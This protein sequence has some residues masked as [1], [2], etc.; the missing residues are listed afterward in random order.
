V[1][2]VRL[3]YANEKQMAYKNSM[4]A[5]SQLPRLDDVAS[6]L[7]KPNMADRTKAPDSN[8]T[9]VNVVGSILSCPNAK[10]HS[11]E[12]A[13]KAIMARQVAKCIFMLLLTPD[14]SITADHVISRAMMDSK[15]SRFRSESI[16]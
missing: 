10:L 5:A 16:P 12:L 14:L 9:V 13:A 4:A 7:L 15:S 2:V 8:L 11:T 6:L 3:T 1:P